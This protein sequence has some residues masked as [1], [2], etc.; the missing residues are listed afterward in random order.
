MPSKSQEPQQSLVVHQQPQS[1]R[2]PRFENSL[3][4]H[5]SIALTNA[6]DQLLNSPAAA[7]RR[8]MWMGHNSVQVVDVDAHDPIL[9]VQARIMAR[10]RRAKMMRE[11]SSFLDHVKNVLNDAVAP[12]SSA[13]PTSPS[14]KNDDEQTPQQQ[15]QQHP[16]T[17]R[18]EQEEVTS[19]TIKARVDAGELLISAY[20]GTPHEEAELIAY[21]AFVHDRMLN[22]IRE[23]IKRLER[24]E[25]LSLVSGTDGRHSRRPETLPSVDEWNRLPPTEDADGKPLDRETVLA[26]RRQ[27]N[28]DAL[29]TSRAHLGF[30]CFRPYNFSAEFER[31]KTL[32]PVNNQAAS[33]A[34]ENKPHQ[35][36]GSTTATA[37]S[38][39]KKDDDNRA[40]SPDATQPAETKQAAPSS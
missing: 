8:V 30:R 19:Q 27:Y 10:N 31:Q 32:S 4:T 38:P 14:N 5:R 37:E 21:N 7:T 15:H 1:A 6:A 3:Q 9:D 33:P 18:R 17:A 35:E 25:E 24:G 28:H 34:A 29:T 12:P 39:S 40:A 23:E 36:N 16:S 2:S 20:D 13:R 22:I 11:L 26:A